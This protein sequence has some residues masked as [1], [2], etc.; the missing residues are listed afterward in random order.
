MKKSLLLILLVAATSYIYAG[1]E[2]ENLD[3]EVIGFELDDLSRQREDL[4]RKLQASKTADADELSELQFLTKEERRDNKGT[5]PSP[6]GEL[7]KQLKEL[8]RRQSSLQRLWDAD[9]ETPP[10]TN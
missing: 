4:E 1:P 7:R 6:T 10:A 3:I 5:S 8:K 2:E 9:V